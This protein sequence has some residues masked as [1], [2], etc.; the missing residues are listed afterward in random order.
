MFVEE[1][2]TLCRNHSEILPRVSGQS[3]ILVGASV[4]ESII[5]NYTAL[6][7]NPDWHVVPL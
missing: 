7:V 5:D 4:R 2:T 3:F 6:P 1:K